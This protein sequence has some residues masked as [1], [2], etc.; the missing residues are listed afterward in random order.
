ME[1][2]ILE[3]LNYSPLYQDN[4]SNHLS[5]AIM[6]LFHLGASEKQLSE[7]NSNYTAQLEKIDQFDDIHKLKQQYLK[8]IVD[9]SQILPVIIN[10]LIPYITT[11]G[12]HGVIRTSYILAEMSNKFLK[13]DTLL[14][15]LSLS[16]AYWNV[17]RFEIKYN[18]SN[19][20]LEEKIQ[21]F[22]QLNLNNLT[23][24]PNLIYKDL[25]LISHTDLYLKCSGVFNYHPL[26]DVLLLEFA[27]DTYIKTCDFT[28]IHMITLLHAYHIV[29]P[30]L[31]HE[32]IQIIQS[33]LWNN[34]LAAA[35]RSHRSKLD[36][37]KMLS[38][39][40]IPIN[41]VL[42]SQDDHLI[43]LYYSLTELYKITNNQKCIVALNVLMSKYQ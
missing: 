11:G 17:T 30:Y 29:E 28:A 7:F 13:P 2:Y 32:N 21:Q 25:E 40:N 15:E 20:D 24:P 4:L 3:N 9:N 8:E 5:M 16:L 39:L 31:N 33:I 37:I 38:Y 34:L 36:N 41:K 22:K 12:F 1:K 10:E 19:I 27:L 6:A 18:K 35:I 23:F 14:H 43:K 42:N 26:N